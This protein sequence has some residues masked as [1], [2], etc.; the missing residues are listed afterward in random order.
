[1]ISPRRSPRV[2]KHSKAGRPA[3][4]PAK[5]ELSS[6]DAALT[7]LNEQHRLEV[8]ERPGQQLGGG[9]GVS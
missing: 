8:L 5:R 1:M 9:A 7:T 2:H 6:R 3:Q 4:Q